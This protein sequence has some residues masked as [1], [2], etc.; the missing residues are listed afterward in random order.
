VGSELIVGGLW[1]SSAIVHVLALENWGAIVANKASFNAF[2]PLV[3]WL[4]ILGL[5]VLW[6]ATHNRVTIKALLC[7]LLLNGV[8]ECLFKIS[9]GFRW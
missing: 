8:V 4:L 5:F 1:H 3:C 6:L 2:R 9:S 7:L